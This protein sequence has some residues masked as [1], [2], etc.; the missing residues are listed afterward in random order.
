MSAPTGS[1]WTALTAEPLETS[2]ASQWAAVETCGALVAFEGIVRCDSLD[3]NGVTAIDYECHLTSA[4]PRL[5][6]IADAA[7]VRWPDLGRIVLWHRTG[8]VALG[9]AS[10]L[11][12]VSAPHRDAA[13][14]AARFCID[15]TKQCVPIWKHEHRGADVTPTSHGVDIID[16]DEAARR[17]GADVLD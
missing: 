8:V 4:V 9:D 1:T 6:E 14:T 2:R 15:V 3:G 12:V 11:V 16:V 7:R 13:F 17:W 10:V 5:G